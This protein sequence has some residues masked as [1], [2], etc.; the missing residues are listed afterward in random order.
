MGEHPQ[1][2]R[3]NLLL[4]E[5]RLPSIRR[6]HR[7][8]AREVVSA[9]G[10]FLAYLHALLEEETRDRSSR[11]NERR[12]KEARF[13]Q[14]KLLSEL[15]PEALPKGVSMAQLWELASGEYLESASNI[16]AIGSSGTG[17]TH[18][19][20]GLAVEACH[21]GRRVRAYTAA[22]LV[23]E[24]AE[25]QEAHQLHRYLRRL[26]SLD[27][28]LID[29]LGYLPIDERGADLLFQAFSERN[30]RGSLILNSNLPFSEWGQIFRNERLAVALLDRVTHR[31]HILEMDGESYRLRSARGGRNN[32]PGRSRRPQDQ[33]PKE[34]Q[35]TEDEEQQEAED[36]EQQGEETDGR[37]DAPDTCGSKDD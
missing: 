18:V 13:R 28:V 16:I 31:A 32:P 24:L 9:G 23:S 25:A 2:A 22:E 11:R 30:E 7:R 15:D 35:E 36:E 14:V 37:P 29:E 19:C 20:T 8:V 3:V 1:E 10:D 4:T 5:L 26:S 33:Q 12:V 21:Q 27:L 6:I 17:K 34:K